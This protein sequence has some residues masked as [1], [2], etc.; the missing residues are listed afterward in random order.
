M[1]NCFG[2]RFIFATIMGVCASTVTVLL[3]FDGATYLKIIG[4]IV[5]IF[6]IAQSYTDRVKNGTK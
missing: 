4:L 1:N 6:T 2:K 3:K 5:G